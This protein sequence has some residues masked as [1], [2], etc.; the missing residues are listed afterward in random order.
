MGV[1]GE[2]RLQ[3]QSLG[4]RKSEA[5][6]PHCVRAGKRTGVYREQLVSAARGGP[7][8]AGGTADVTLGRGG[9]GLL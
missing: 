8:D 9:K 7:T 6:Y 2:R 3:Q 1:V 4:L 5:L